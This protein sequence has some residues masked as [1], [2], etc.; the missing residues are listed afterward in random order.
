MAV[1]MVVGITIYSVLSNR[2]IRYALDNEPT[3][4][5]IRLLLYNLDDEYMKTHSIRF[6]IAEANELLIKKDYYSRPYSA[7]K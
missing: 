4:S 3:V 1:S 5:V 7:E 2:I 6:M